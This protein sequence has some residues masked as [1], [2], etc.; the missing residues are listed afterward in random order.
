MPTPH[1]LHTG[2]LRPAQAMPLRWGLQVK[3]LHPLAPSTRASHRAST[4]HA[5]GKHAN[6]ATLRLGLGKCRLCGQVMSLPP[7]SE[8][9]SP[10]FSSS[11][12]RKWESKST[13]TRAL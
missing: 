9:T 7:V 13:R 12:C 4:A 5:V 6:E 11:L 10:L 1:L 8:L 2:V 3:L